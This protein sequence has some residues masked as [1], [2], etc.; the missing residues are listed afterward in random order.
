MK[1]KVWPRTVPIQTSRDPSTSPNTAPAAKAK[2]EPGNNTVTATTYKACVCPQ[3]C[4]HQMSKLAKV[5]QY[6]HHFVTA[7]A[8]AAA[9]QLKAL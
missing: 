2:M 8:Y 6:G 1:A 9:M 7:V 3:S 5:R 4:E